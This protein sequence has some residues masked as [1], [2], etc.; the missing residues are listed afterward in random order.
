MPR[1][2]QNHVARESRGAVVGLAPVDIFTRVV[3]GIVCD[4]ID[5][6]ALGVGYDEQRLDTSQ[7]SM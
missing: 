3:R 1:H 6:F 5:L 2:I 4:G 7:T